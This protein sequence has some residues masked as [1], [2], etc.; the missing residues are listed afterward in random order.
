[1]LLKDRSTAGRRKP[2]A[3]PALERI[4]RREDGE[5]R[6]ERRVD[7][8]GAL[9]HPA[10]DE[11]VTVRDGR[12]RPRVGREDRL[13][14]R[15][16]AAGREVRGRHV[17]AREELLH[18]EP[19]AD[20]ARRED[21]DLL[22][23]EAERARGVHRSR[24]GIILAAASRRRVRDARVHDHGLRLG[25]LQV[26]PRDDDGRG[27]DPVPRPHR[28]PHRRHERPDDRDVRLSGRPDPRR[29]ARSREPLWRGDGHQTSTPESRSPAVSGWPNRRLTFCTACPAAP[30]P[31]LSSA[32]ITIVRSVWRSSKTPI[33]AP[34]VC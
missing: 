12:L 20:H 8:P 22:R 24:P 21:D 28:A 2:S 6:R 15:R 26:A 4:V 9:R 5:H 30:L 3:S 23:L 33:S 29:D 11:P 32:Q 18:R 34:S 13:R 31:R 1:M 19:R 14:R 27:L 10:H 7:H 17:D 16:A 25:E